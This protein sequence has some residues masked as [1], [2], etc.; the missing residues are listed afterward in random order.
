VVNAEMN[1]ESMGVETGRKC[2]GFPRQAAEHCHVRTV[3]FARFLHDRYFYKNG[4]RPQQ[5][6]LNRRE[7]PMRFPRKFA[8]KVVAGLLA[9]GMLISNTG[10]VFAQAARTANWTVSITYQNIGTADTP[11]TLNLYPENSS[12]PITLGPSALPASNPLKQGAATSF[13]VGSVNNPSFTQGNGVMSSEQPV[14]ATV[15]QFS[16]DPGFKM[17]LLYNGFSDSKSATQYLVATTLLNRFSRTTVFSI[18]NTESQPI[19]VTVNFYNADTNPASLAS[20]KTLVIPANSSKFIRMD[21]AGDTGLPA[22]TTVFNGSA[23]ITAK[24]QGSQT[25][26]EV[27]AAASEYYVDRPVA[28]NFE[29]QP[30]SDGGTLINMATALCRRFGL[31]TFYAIQN[32]SLTQATSIT[33]RYFNLDGTP[34][35]VDGP[36]AVNAGGKTSPNTCAPS[37]GTDMSNF[38]GSA[39]IESTGGV[40]IVAI[41]KAQGEL[42]TP[43]AAQAEFLTA[44]LGEKTGSQKLA[45][46]F[47]RW[48]SDAR[49]NDPTN[50]G[51]VQRT[52]IAIQNIGGTAIP[53]GQLKIEYRDVDGALIATQTNS[54]PLAPKAKFNSDANA[55]GAL[56]QNGMNAG[57]FGYYPANKFG[58]GVQ[59]IGPAGAQLIAI[60]RVQHP[61]AGE[62]YNAVPVP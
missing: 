25:D 47:V 24:I 32:A 22:S 14:V 59:I 35:A 49:F 19:D 44:F 58:G 21:E 62:D 54:E 45:M 43:P 27:V 61:G 11:V 36:I 52:F 28:T 50:N 56:G 37:D 55:A 23:I 3:L 29:G 41:G 13:F 53:A 34:K 30:L 5:V 51:G 31:Q 39:T 16:P 20:T 17:R 38:T 46:P 15:V 4:H 57:E 1:A 26:A 2:P 60:A 6:S 8:T 42:P 10:A 7:V 9:A 12:T 18:Q 40:P 48:G 33:V